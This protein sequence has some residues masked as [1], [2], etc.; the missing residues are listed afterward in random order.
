MNQ[1]AL[2]VEVDAREVARKQSF[3]ASIE[4]CAELADLDPKQIQLDLKL[5]KSQWSR[6][7]H[8]GEG[9]VW[10]KLAS[11]MDL[12]G[13]DAP[14]LWMVHQRGWDLNAMRR[15]ETELERQLRESR[16]ENAA[17]RRVLAGT[18]P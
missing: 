4:L 6:W 7:A 13:N 9:I 10:P 11:V 16:E 18:R 5:D 3:G 8:G 14:V 15:R 17:L 12:C 2:A 1:I